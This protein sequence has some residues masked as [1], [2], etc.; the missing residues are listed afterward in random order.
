MFKTIALPVDLAHKTDLSRGITVAVDLAKHY[1]AN[2]AFVGVTGSG[3]GS[4]A[5]SPEGFTQ[6]L[7][8]FASEVGTLYGLDIGFKSVV[9][10]DPAI[11][12]EDRVGES[13]KELNADLVVMP[14][15]KPGLLEHVFA[16]HAG[17][18]AS[19]SDLSVFIVR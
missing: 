1:D 7:E 12:L 2:L 3:P 15:H 17:R 5:R 16:S 19:H 9:S 14:S 8:K 6:E 11:D 4:V 13:V 18:F 10:N